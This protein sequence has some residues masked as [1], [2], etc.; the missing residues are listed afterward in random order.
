MSKSK[1]PSKTYSIYAIQCTAT[2]RVYVG[3]TINFQSRVRAHFNEL[4]TRR[5]RYSV[6]D[7]KARRRE[8]TCWQLDYDKHGE[9]AFGVFLIE[10][11]VPADIESEREEHYMR[12]YDS[13]NPEH[14]YNIKRPKALPV[15][16][17]RGAPAVVRAGKEG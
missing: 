4:K 2:G 16:F 8:D 1:D 17:V 6:G 14:G 13:A 3:S 15:E 11:N 12:L 10:E 7:G 5:K 9:N